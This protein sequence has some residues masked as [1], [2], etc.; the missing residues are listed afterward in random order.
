MLK[1]CWIAIVGLLLFP[2]QTFSKTCP[3]G[4]DLLSLTIGGCVD[5]TDTLKIENG[6]FVWRS[7]GHFFTAY[8][9]GKHP[10]CQEQNRKTFIQTRSN[11]RF[12]NDAPLEAGR[13]KWTHRGFWELRMPLNQ[14]QPGISIQGDSFLLDWRPIEGGLRKS[15]ASRTTEDGIGWGRFEEILNLSNLDPSGLRIIDEQKGAH[16]YQV[17]LQYCYD[18]ANE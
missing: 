13:S 7:F 8:P 17:E 12:L 18:S 11:L 3:Q 4:M 16:W 10:T 1:M 5:F 9:P 14:L 15:S 6:D 2:S